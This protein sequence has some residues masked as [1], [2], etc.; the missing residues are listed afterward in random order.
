M[1]RGLLFAAISLLS[2]MASAKAMPT[3]DLVGTWDLAHHSCV[4][5]SVARQAAFDLQEQA[6]TAEELGQKNRLPLPDAV[7]AKFDASS[8]VIDAKYFGCDYQLV[9]PYAAQQGMISYTSGKIASQCDSSSIELTP[10]PFHF[11]IKSNHLISSGLLNTLFCEKGQTSIFD[12][13]RRH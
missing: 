12:L 7:W 13:V 8:L 11:K 3:N 10:Q 5:S 6:W 4:K 9:S 2:F 1:G